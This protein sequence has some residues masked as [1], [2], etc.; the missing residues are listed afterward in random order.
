MGAGYVGGPTMAVLAHNCP[1][2]QVTVVDV[3]TDKISRWN[4]HDTSKIPVFEPGLEKIVKET[5]FKN[6]HFSTDFENAIKKADI[7][8]ISV[9]TPT[10]EKGV[11]AGH[12]SD[13]R[14]VESSARL[15]G[16]FSQGHTIVVEKST[17]PIRTA[18]TIMSIL[19]SIKDSNDKKTFDVLSNPEFLAEGTAI[20]DLQFPDRVLIGGN[21]SLAIDVLERIYLN[22]VDKEKIIRTNLWSSELTKLSENAFL[23]QRVSSINAVAELCE[24]TGANINEVSYAIGEDKRIG[25]KFLKA[26]P[27]FGGSCFNKDILNLIYLCEYFGLNEAS[28]YWEEV[29]K[30][31]E[32]QKD[33]ISKVI[34]DKL[35]GTLTEKK[36]AILG[37]SFK[38]N[39]NDTRQSPAIKICKNLLEEGAYLAIHDPKVS[40]SQIEID[41]ECEEINDPNKM[42]DFKKWKFFE[43]IDDA[44]YSAD[45]VVIL[46][47][48][49]CYQN[50][51]WEEISNIMRAP[52]WL[53]DTRGVVDLEYTKNLDL[54]VWKLGI[55]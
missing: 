22:W 1:N 43:K 54:N 6:L 37:F 45:A 46:C 27:G 25:S 24:V 44:I 53:F 14:F 19:D 47:D 8:F 2:L 9:N 41:L 16:K 48:W 51:D 12:A 15:V 21:N 5:R 32:H 26:G 40:K 42:H 4:D 39:T 28:K 38:S 36:I 49:E 20:N 23:A 29:V 55:G 52:A 17:V 34:A 7:I 18:A 50:L 3:N 11:G 30:I 10:K 13:L 33:R 31:N 35:F